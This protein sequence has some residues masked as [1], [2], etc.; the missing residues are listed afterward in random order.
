MDKIISK[1]EYLEECKKSRETEGG[2]VPLRAQEISN[3]FTKD[4][5]DSEDSE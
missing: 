4:S 5:E 3:I 1:R 2:N